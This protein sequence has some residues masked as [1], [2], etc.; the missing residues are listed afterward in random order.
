MISFAVLLALVVNLIMTRLGCC[1]IIILVRTL[2]PCMRVIG[3]GLV[4][5]VVPP[6]PVLM[7]AVGWKLVIVVVTIM[8]L[9]LVILVT[10]VACTRL[11]AL[12]LTI[13]MFEGVGIL[14]RV[15]INAMLV[16]CV[17]VC[18]VRVIFR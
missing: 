1:E 5:L 9:T 13:C 2:G 7:Q 3:V 14:R 11:V 16:F 6:T 4:L 17:C 18:L 10:M 8:V 12:I 15:V